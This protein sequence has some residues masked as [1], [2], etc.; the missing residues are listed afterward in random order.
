MLC[1]NPTPVLETLRN[2][3]GKND[4]KN[5]GTDVLLTRSKYQ[6]P[7][8]TSYEK[9]MDK[10]GWLIRYLIL[11]AVIVILALKINLLMFVN[12]SVGLYGITTSSVLFFTLFFSYIKFRDPYSK[13][14]N[15]NLN[16]SSH[17]PFVSIIIP[18][19]NEEG[20]I[21]FCVESCINSTYQ[22]KEVIVIDDA[23][24]DNTS[25]I[26][27][28][29]QKEYPLN[30]DT[31]RKDC[32]ILHVTH[33]PVNVGKKKAIEAATKIAKGEIFVFVDSDAIISSDAVENAVKIFQSDRKI[34][35]L[36]G[37]PRQMYAEHNG[38]SLLRKLQDIRLDN[39]CRII[40]GMESSYMSVTC[41]SGNFSAYRRVAIQNFIHEWANDMFLGKEFK[42][43]TDRRL[44]GYVTCTR[45][46]AI[47]GETKHKNLEYGYWKVAY[48]Q[49]LRIYVK[50]PETLQSLITQR[51]RWQKSFIRSIFSTGSIFWQRPLCIAIIYYLQI[52]LRLV[53]PFVVI[54]SLLILPLLGDYT[55][56]LYYLSG[57]FFVSMIYGIDFRL[58]HPGNS[59]W[60]YR[61]LLQ[62]IT[63]FILTWLIF[64]AA[65]TIKKMNWR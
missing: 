29:I 2:H 61:P 28:E 17:I 35:A 53:R 59:Y 16:S 62:L 54:Q 51:I 65:I 9:E 4:G 6:T 48:S 27:D 38:G 52:G 30:N 12:F 26:L 45:L 63:I 55:T 60:F 64:Y 37:Q 31:N 7:K 56:A 24:T 18:V 25:Q 46:P 22:K 20:N 58:R 21:R 10:K 42:F 34:G 57:I 11:G 19:K 47:K 41:C 32:P 8:S 23:S 50:E 1:S 36:T 3:D 15:F 40:K 44:T 43:C 14:Q 13:A 49:S 39:S 5:D 33:L